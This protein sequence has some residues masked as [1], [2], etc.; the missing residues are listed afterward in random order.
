M[1]FAALGGLLAFAA[2][3]IAGQA[4]GIITSLLLRGVDVWEGVRIGLLVSLAAVRTEIVVTFAPV[5][6]TE[7]L[8]TADLGYL[9]VPMALTIG[10]V[11]LAAR[12]GRRAAR[13]WPEAPVLA[14]V[15]VAAA[16]AGVPVGVVAGLAAGLASIPF[17]GPFPG[18]RLTVGADAASAAIWAGVLAGV[19]AGVGAAI[20]GGRGRMSAD[21]L[22]GGVTA[23]LWAL[24]LLVIG[25]L[26]VA[27]LEP[28]ATRAYVD[29][30]RGFGPGGAALFGAHLLALPAQSAL[31]LVPA[32]GSCV[33]LVVA[34]SAAARSCPWTL[35]AL[36]SPVGAILPLPSGSLELSPTLWVL[37]AAPPLAA[38]LGGHRAGASQEPRSAIVRGA[39]SGVVFGAIAMLGA[40]FATPRIVVPSL[41][42]WLPLEISVWSWRT[43][44]LLC[45]WGVIGGALG[46]WVAGRAYEPP[47][48]SPTSA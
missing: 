5:A 44:G 2:L 7:V 29:G 28:Q 27:T 3:L 34:G 21:V 35:E 17:L 15:V 11:W 6:G 16:G 23:Y 25:V 18:A 22:R 33:D 20:E 41:A 31:L 30:L 4:L 38:F 10:F 14:R 46:G 19:G 12:A 40:A 32:A 8:P 42:G 39:G 1:A 43:A 9:L 45:L 47:G 26:V 48:P 37:A 13:M 24:G 36:R